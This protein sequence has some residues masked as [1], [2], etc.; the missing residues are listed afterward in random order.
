VTPN[1]APRNP[2]PLPDEAQLVQLA[3][4]G[5]ADAFA[6]LY[7]A[8]VDRVYRY[9]YFRVTDDET[10][11]D[12]TS[13]VFLKAWENLGR[14]RPGG[15][16]LAWLYTIAHNAVI[17]HYRTRK[18]AV[19]LEEVASLVVEKDDLEDRVEF[20]FDLE[21]IRGGLQQLTADQQQVLLLRFIAQMS[22]EEVARAMGK[23]EG[24]IRALQMRALHTL[25]KY[26]EKEKFYERP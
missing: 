7:D 18:S 3:R 24:A 16:F 26:M 14:Y 5:D 25:K 13:Q 11:E 10:A 2:G 22:T 4:S 6:R 19:P 1:S 12:L 20:Q 9:V 23:R 15:P 17:D 8:Y 21:A